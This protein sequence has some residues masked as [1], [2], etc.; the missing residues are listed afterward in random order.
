MNENL[1]KDFTA[2][3]HDYK[4]REAAVQSEVLGFFSVLDA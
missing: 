4:H 3:S 2:L 1:K